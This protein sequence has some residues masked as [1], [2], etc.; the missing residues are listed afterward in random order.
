MACGAAARQR[1]TFEP[2][3][4]EGKKCRGRQ[5]VP[6]EDR[7]VRNGSSFCSDG[8][9]P[10]RDRSFHVPQIG[11][12]GPEILVFLLFDR[13]YLRFHDSRPDCER[14]IVRRTENRIDFFD[15]TRIG[16]KGCLEF[17]YFRCLRIEG[18]RECGECFARITDGPDKHLADAFGG[19]CFSGSGDTHGRRIER[20]Q[21]SNTCARRRRPPPDRPF[22]VCTRI[23]SSLFTHARPRRNRVRRN[24][25]VRSR[26]HGHPRPSRRSRCGHP[27]SASAP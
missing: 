10:V 23:G 13:A 14:P 18:Q 27:S 24:R 20:N 12:P 3:A 8:G 11:R 2:V 5:V 25:R 16:K 1:D 4:V 7:A 6:A 22:P 9:E 17:E 19:H 15:Q 21:C 26:L